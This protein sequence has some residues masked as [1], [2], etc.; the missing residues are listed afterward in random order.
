MPMGLKGWSSLEMK[1]QDVVSWMDIAAGIRTPALC[2]S[3]VCSYQQPPSPAPAII[4][5]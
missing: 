1:F 3:S 4:L 2:K 5:F